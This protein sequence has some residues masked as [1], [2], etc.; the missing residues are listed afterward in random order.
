MCL[1]SFSLELKKG[2]GS[3]CVNTK[4]ALAFYKQKEKGAFELV[5]SKTPLSLWLGILQHHF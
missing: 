2:R 5:N 4:D 1:Y 3:L